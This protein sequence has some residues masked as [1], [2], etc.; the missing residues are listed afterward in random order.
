M[1]KI[2]RLCVKKKLFK[3]KPF[4]T[5]FKFIPDYKNLKLNNIINDHK[6]LMFIVLLYIHTYHT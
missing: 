3:M 4:I 6:L 2:H 5:Y 1:N